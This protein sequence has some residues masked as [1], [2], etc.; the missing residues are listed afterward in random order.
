M[1]LFG[2]GKPNPARLKE[3][4][5]V[6]ALALAL[7]DSDAEVRAQAFDALVEMIVDPKFRH[8]NTAALSALRQAGDTAVITRFRAMLTETSPVASSWRNSSVMEALVLLDDVEA[9]EEYYD[10]HAGGDLSNGLFVLELTG[11]LVRYATAR[12]DLRLLRKLLVSGPFPSPD[13]LRLGSSAS[14][15]LDPHISPIESLIPLKITMGDVGKTFCELASVDDLLEVAVVGRGSHALPVVFDKLAETGT[16]R[17]LPTLQAIAEKSPKGR[18][19]RNAIAAIVGR[20]PT[21][22][23]TQLAQS[24]APDFVAEPALLALCERA[25]PPSAP[26]IAGA[27]G[28]PNEAI[29]IAAAGA[30]ARVGAPDAVALLA[31]VTA[32]ASVARSNAAVAA[33]GAIGSAAA[34]DVLLALP[35]KRLL[36]PAILAAIAAAGEGD[37]LIRRVEAVLSEMPEEQRPH[38]V[39]TLR[40]LVGGPELVR[41]QESVARTHVES[42]EDANWGRRK[43]AT[44]A[45]GRIGG[46][47]AVRALEA[48][49]AHETDLELQGVLAEAF[50]DA[51]K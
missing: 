10:R 17:C 37:A 20:L 11:L 7:K 5:D 28:H 47:A 4:G 3:T 38:V 50:R 19:S 16:E 45:L 30:V 41:L 48:R 18:R 27:V 15:S 31:P 39:R 21:D 23:L 26:L 42:L 43:R 13:A 1:R 29:A 2:L 6:H 49:A 25:E 51:A 8:M 40:G 44:E 46:A 14:D 34:I 24:D 36:E 32:H 9:L 12:R 33:L 22:R 35:G